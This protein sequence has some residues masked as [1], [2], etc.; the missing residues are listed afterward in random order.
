M[1]I[2]QERMIS[3]INAAVEYRNAYISLHNAMI[4][5]TKRGIAQNQTDMYLARMAQTILELG[6]RY[7]AIMVLE[8]QNFSRN[9]KHNQ[10]EKERLARIRRDKGIPKRILRPT[11]INETNR[12]LTTTL[13]IHEE[14]KAPQSLIVS[15]AD[16]DRINRE[17]EAELE[18]DAD[19]HDGVTGIYPVDKGD[20]DD[21][22]DEN[23]E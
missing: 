10:L 1:A 16:Y 18:K 8:A 5:D 13:T 20:D 2:K 7:N 19:Y 17:I 14:I 9:F 6:E 23:I 22:T 11:A 15:E 3:L 21:E 4:E 12:L